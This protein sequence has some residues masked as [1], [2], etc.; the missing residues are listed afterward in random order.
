M[1]PRGRLG[2]VLDYLPVPMS[3]SW[4]SAL[5]EALVTAR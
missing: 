5:V 4:I 2:D 3:T 1:L